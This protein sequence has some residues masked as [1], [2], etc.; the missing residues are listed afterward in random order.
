[1]ENMNFNQLQ[2]SIQLMNLILQYKN[3]RFRK[4]NC[5]AQGRT[6]IYSRVEPLE[7]FQFLFITPS[8]YYYTYIIY[9]Y[10]YNIYILLLLFVV[11]V[12]VF[13]FFYERPDPKSGSANTQLCDPGQ[14]T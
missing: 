8:I 3:L 1:M 12:G 9:K 4:R 14:V 11:V 6:A 5:F 2:P 7:S 10:I 13:D